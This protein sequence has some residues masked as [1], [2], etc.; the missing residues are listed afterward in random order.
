MFVKLKLKE[1][2]DMEAI[3]LEEFEAQKA[4]LLRTNRY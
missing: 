3:T 4:Q 1:L 2:L